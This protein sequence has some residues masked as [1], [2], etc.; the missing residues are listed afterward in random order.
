[1]TNGLLKSELEL[2]RIVI[3]RRERATHLVAAN[4]SLVSL[5]HETLI[6]Q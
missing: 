1:M 4:L 5:V 2:F 6:F 3:Q